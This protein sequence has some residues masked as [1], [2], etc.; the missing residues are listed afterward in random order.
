MSQNRFKLQVNSFASGTLSH[1]LY[2]YCSIN[3]RQSKEQIRKTVNFYRF[4]E[5]IENEMKVVNFNNWYWENKHSV[6]FLFALAAYINKMENRDTYYSPIMRQ[7][8]TS[9]A[10]IEQRINTNYNIINQIFAA[11]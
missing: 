2:V 7:L 8:K 9:Y 10:A 4:K 11:I 6:S 5:Y 1:Q 3:G